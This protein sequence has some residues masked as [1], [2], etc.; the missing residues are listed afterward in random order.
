M[1]G[2]ES[3]GVASA[4][5]DLFVGRPWVL[6]QQQENKHPLIAEYTGWLQRCGAVPVFMDA[7]HHDA[8]VALT[9]HLPQLASTAL[10]AALDTQQLPSDSLRISGSGLRDMTR[11]ALS[12]WDV[13]A[14][15]I[16]SNSENVSHALDVYIDKLTILRDNIGTRG[17][18]EDFRLAAGLARRIRQGDNDVE[19]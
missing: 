11:L 1:A 13:W 4:A 15:I 12:S 19:D 8:V 14:D 17:I 3:R 16:G 7:A 9:S 2:K 18:A 10:A 5:A 6:T